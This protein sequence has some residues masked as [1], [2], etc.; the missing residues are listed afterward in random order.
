MEDGYIGQF[1]ALSEG[2]FMRAGEKYEIGARSSI[3]VKLV[4][5][6]SQ[7]GDADIL[8]RITASGSYIEAEDLQLV[9]ANK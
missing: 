4:F 9:I 5:K 8:F 7:S 6:A 2:S 3:N 1:P